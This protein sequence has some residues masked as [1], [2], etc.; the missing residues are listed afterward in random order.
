MAWVQDA[1]SRVLLVRQ[2]AGQKLWTLPGGEYGPENHCRKRF[3][4]FEEAGLRAEAD[5]WIGTGH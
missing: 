4:V 1:E 3:C 5:A 2:T